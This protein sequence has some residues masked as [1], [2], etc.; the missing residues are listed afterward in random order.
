MEGHIL[1]T[2][3]AI[4]GTIIMQIWPIKLCQIQKM[5][6]GNE[7]SFEF[8]QVEQIDQNLQVFLMPSSKKRDC[9]VCAF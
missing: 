1:V 4:C 9:F 2:F 6:N 8:L 5:G 3:F 7:F